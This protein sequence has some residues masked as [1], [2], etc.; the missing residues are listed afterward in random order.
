MPVDALW[1]SIDPE[2]AEMELAYSTMLCGRNIADGRATMCS[3]VTLTIAH[4][5]GMGDA[6]SGEIYD[7]YF[8]PAYLRLLRHATPS[9]CVASSSG[10]MSLRA[11]RSLPDE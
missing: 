3:I 9:G 8:L 1:H 6:E 4:H 11:T 10:M 5:R 7:I 2:V